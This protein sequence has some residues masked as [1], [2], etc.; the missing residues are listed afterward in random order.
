MANQTFIEF[1]DS[2]CH[3]YQ[4]S[5][6]RNAFALK[7]SLAVPF[8]VAIQPLD[9]AMGL[10]V[11]APDGSVLPEENGLSEE[12]KH[13]MNGQAL[14][15][16]LKKNG[17]KVE[18]AVAL[19]PKHWATLRVVTLPATNAEELHDMARFEAERHIPFNVERHVINYQAISLDDIEGARAL[20][21]AIDRPPA[22]QVMDIF[23]AAG[24]HLEGVA[25]SS[26]TLINMLLH[27]G[28]WNPEQDETVAYVNIG[29][30]NTDILIL[31][32]GE[33][34][35][36]RSTSVGVQ[37]LSQALAEVAAIVP[38]PVVHNEHDEPE[39]G[40]ADLD[41]PITNGDLSPTPGGIAFSAPGTRA[42]APDPLQY[43]SIRLIREIRRTLDYAQ[44]EFECTQIARVF[45]SG[46]GAHTPDLDM[47]LETSFSAPMEVLDPFEEPVS[48]QSALRFS[49][50]VK[51]DD[52]PQSFALAVGAMLG[53]KDDKRFRIDL[54]PPAYLD[55]HRSA[56]RRR[57]LMMLT[58]LVLA[59]LVG[60][61]FVAKQ[62]LAE[63]ETILAGLKAQ[64]EQD[65]KRVKEIR[66]K[67]TVVK[68]LRQNSSDMGSAIA[69]LND[70]SQW[71]DLFQPN[72][73]SISI[74]NFRYNHEKR[75][76]TITG[77]ARTI[78]DHG[79]FMER[80]D[81]LDHF[82]MVIPGLRE[83]TRAPNM[84]EEVESINVRCTIR[85]NKEK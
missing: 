58:T 70:I 28:K 30:S 1:R 6:S 82:S 41:A 22:N 65:N 66:D 39:P 49:C 18:A 16:T 35:F 68:I 42:A 36:A 14:R 13:E 23:A 64:V 54:I 29:T 4:W 59:L 50:K 3:V 79:N 2:G 74:D 84:R 33:P 7:A 83:K 77:Y 72:N 15:Q 17:I 53:E 40:F 57:I 5:G 38:E 10:G 32:K 60:G 31:S 43:R 24:I 81:K 80:L 34:I 85:K 73:P 61:V 27:S 9:P 78:A 37:K 71:K 51:T 45:V 62:K 46:Q 48:G 63:K 75:S 76:V 11:E 52:S 21:A 20:L 44:R 55:A 8:E 69:I 19:V 47:A 56:K 25:V 67:E 12:R 26:V